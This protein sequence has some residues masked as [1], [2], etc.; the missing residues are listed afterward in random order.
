MSFRLRLHN[1]IS[2]FSVIVI[3][4]VPAFRLTT[5][6]YTNSCFSSMFCFSD[7]TVRNILIDH[8]LI[9]NGKAHMLEKKNHLLDMS[10][11]YRIYFGSF[12]SSSALKVETTLCLCLC[13][14]V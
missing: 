6:L 12:I 3:L 8:P 11:V 10:D 1:F 14:V 9:I 2:I 13:T 4:N 5:V 7:T